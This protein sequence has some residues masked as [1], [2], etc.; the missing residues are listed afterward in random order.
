MNPA[1]LLARA[2]EFGFRVA[3]EGGEPRL[4]R[5]LPGARLPAS[6]LAD[7]KAARLAVVAHVTGEP[8]VCG[9]CRAAV[10]RPELVGWAVCGLAGCPVRCEQEPERVDAGGGLGGLGGF[11]AP[12]ADA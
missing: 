6:L 7:L 1:A 10:F 11:E 4:V 9:R 12:E 8:V 3:V 5:T 2:G